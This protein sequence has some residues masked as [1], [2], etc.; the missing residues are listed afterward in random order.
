MS[1]WRDAVRVFAF[2]G[3]VTR[4]RAREV[5]AALRLALLSAAIAPLVLA[6]AGC[7]RGAEPGTLVIA[8]ETT[9]RGFDP[10]FSTNVAQ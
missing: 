2:L 9:P 8:L 7:S 5:K 3:R 1:G 10:R 4:A 6:C